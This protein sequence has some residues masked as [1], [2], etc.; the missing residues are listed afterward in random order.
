MKKLHH[1]SL[2]EGWSVQIYSSDR[3]L[4]MF[5]TPAHVWLFVAG[6]L[7]GA[8]L[9]FALLSHSA[10]IQCSSA[11]PQPMTPPLSVD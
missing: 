2:D 9:V 1:S 11:I 7:L 8:F 3:R 10:S 6:I 5:L 4:L